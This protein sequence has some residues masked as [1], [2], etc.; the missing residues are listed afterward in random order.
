MGFIMKKLSIGVIA[1]L[2]ATA[3]FASGPELSFVQVHV[4]L[5]DVGNDIYPSEYTVMDYGLATGFTF[6]SFVTELAFTQNRI[7]DG[8]D[9]IS[10]NTT[11]LGIG[12]IVPGGVIA[13]VGETV[14]FF[15][16][17]EL[18]AYSDNLSFYSFGI[19]YDAGMYGLGA[20]YEKLDDFGDGD[21]SSTS[22]WGSYNFSDVGLST[23]L[24]FT[25]LAD[26]GNSADILSAELAYEVPNSQ[27]EIYGNYNCFDFGSDTDQQIGLGVRYTF[28]DG[29]PRARNPFGIKSYPLFF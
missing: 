6:G 25:R 23:T 22:I 10:A 17:G 9:S 16:Y 26:E 12:Y 19:D 18:S 29:K 24:G 13:S 11:T 2:M 20:S 21:V 1:S 14:L 5:D 28:G 27:V 4:G 15:E 7:S 3:S 8:S